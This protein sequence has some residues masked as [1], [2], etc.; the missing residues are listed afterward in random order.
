MVDL[1]NGLLSTQTNA[2]HKHQLPARLLLRSL[3]G[4]YPK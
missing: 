3:T 1:Q 2:I 4:L